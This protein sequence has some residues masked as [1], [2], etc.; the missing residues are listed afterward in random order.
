MTTVH[1]TF[2]LGITYWPRRVGLLFWQ[3]YDRGAV[4]EELAHIAATGFNTVRLCL[5]WEDFQPGPT[6]INSRAMRCLEHALD[7]ASTAGLRVVLSLFPV[8][9]LGQFQI[10]SWANGPDIAGALRRVQQGQPLLI[11]RPP[12]LISVITGGRYRPVQCGD[13]FS[14]PMIVEAQRYLVRETGS[15]FGSHPAVWIWQLGEGFERVHRPTSEQAV[16]QWFRMVSDELR[17]VAPH[18]TCMG[19]V[20]S[21]GLKR[22]SGPRPEH[23]AAHCTMTGVAVDLPETPVEHLVRHT[24]PAAYL[25]MLVAGL[26][27]RRVVVTGIG[28]P[29]IIDGETAGWFED[30]L[31]GRTVLIYRSTAGE[32]AEFIYTALE[33]LYEDGAAGVWLATYADTPAELWQMPPFDRTRCYRTTG[34]VDALGREKPAVG[35]VRDIAKR[36][37]SASTMPS[38]PPAVDAERYWSDPERTFRTWWR[39]FNSSG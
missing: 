16:S 33:R 22:R 36:I 26:A 10:P 28:M 11:V 19:I 37:R 27:E 21:T 9:V 12:G 5:L 34:I 23:V 7:T 30:D 38:Q 14:D 24:N 31:Y 1:E 2:S 17:R 35:A 4:R 15:Y 8:A 29:T 6:R 20:S 13:L 18:A 32:Q 25:H 39:E 3:R